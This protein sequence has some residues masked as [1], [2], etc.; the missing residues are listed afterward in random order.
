MNIRI[1]ETAEFQ[2]VELAHFADLHGCELISHNGD[3]LI[4]G[5]KTKSMDSVVPMYLN[6]T[7]GGRVHQYMVGLL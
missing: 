3:I 4:R 7:D 6:D 2:I 1:D 5:K